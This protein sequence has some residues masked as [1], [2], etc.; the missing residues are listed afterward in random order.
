MCF[1]RMR[2][3]RPRIVGLDEQASCAPERA[4]LVRIAQQ[5]DD[6]AGKGRRIVGGHEVLRGL[7]PE[8]LGADGCRHHRLAHGKRLEDLQARAAAGAKRH[9]V[10]RRFADPWADVLHRSS[11]DDSRPGRE[12]AHTR[13]RV[14]S[15]DRE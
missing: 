3:L 2:D 13:P 15:H 11:D 14:T 1:E 5:R 10:N 9:H 4:P 7:Q 12:I 8:P 6:G